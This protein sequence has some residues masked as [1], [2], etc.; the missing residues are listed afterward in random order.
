MEDEKRSPSPSFLNESHLQSIITHQPSTTTINTT[1]TTND[2][3][4]SAT[5]H[6]SRDELTSPQAPPQSH[7]KR[8]S[9]AYGNHRPVSSVD[10]RSHWC[11]STISRDT[12]T[13]ATNRSRWSTSTHGGDNRRSSMAIT[14]LPPLF[15]SPVPNL[16]LTPIPLPPKEPSIYDEHIDGLA[17]NW[18]PGKKWTT[19]LFVAWLAFISPLASSM[20]APAV[21]LIRREF[22]YEGQD[23]DTFLVSVFIFGYVVS[24]KDGLDVKAARG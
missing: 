21:S 7:N 2:L 8:F 16:G 22:Q 4:S 10:T 20:V 17:R 14:A 3:K 5:R 9:R 24:F 11:W 1:T 19:T 15:F 18:A 12:G 23:Y 13:A 6:D